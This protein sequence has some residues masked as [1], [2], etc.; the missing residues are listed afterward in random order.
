MTVTLRLYAIGILVMIPAIGSGA[1]KLAEAVDQLR[2]ADCAA[3][4]FLSI[5]RSDFF[6]YV[7]TVYGEVYLA[8]DGRYRV[9]LG[10]DTYLHTGDTLYSHSA[11]HNQVTVESGMSYLGQAEQV[12]WLRRLDHWYE[13]SSDG[14]WLYRLTR[15]ESDT[16]GD[17]PGRMTVRIDSLRSTIDWLEYK[18]INDDLNRLIIHRQ[19]LDS[20]CQDSLLTPRFPD[21]VEVIKLP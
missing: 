15:K 1:D 21:T 20:P 7:D 11:K 5:A 2:G 4:E 13:W 17:L 12:S 8:A 3:I 16:A 10:P 6:S 9:R 14:P 19:R 18:D